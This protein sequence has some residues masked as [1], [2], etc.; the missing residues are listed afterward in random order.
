MIKRF[1]YAWIIFICTCIISLVGFGLV[2]NTVGLFY[3]PVCK[4]FNIGRGEVALM[5]TF[6]NIAAALTLAFAGKLMNKI[7]I[8]VLLTSTYL[9]IGLGL[10]GLSM[11]HSIVPF[12]VTWA[13]IGICEPFA[14]LLPIPVLLGNWFEK[15]LG[16]VMGISLGISA[17][18]GAVF[19]PIISSVITGSGWR[20][21]YIVSG[22]IVLIAILP[23]TLFLIK[24]KPENGV[25]PYGHSEN[26][27]STAVNNDS[28]ITLKQALKTPMFYLITLAMISLN[29]VAGF[30]QHI[31]GHIVNVGLPLTVGA[32]VISGVMLGAAA[33]KISIGWM[34]DKLNKSLVILIYGIFGIIGWGGLVV[35]KNASALVACGFI[36]GIGQGILLVSLPYFIR[37][38]FGSKDYSNIY[39]VISMFG[40]FASAAAVSIDGKIFD[41]T[42]SYAVPLWT[43]VALYVVSIMAIIISIN[44]TRRIIKNINR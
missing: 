34:L 42:K 32:S 13:L 22:A 5:T 25:Q 28:G 38:M 36:L 10:M 20:T 35:M 24:F 8:K 21:G 17:I 6:Q 9:V 40:A 18:G 4:A 41:M 30:V 16:T 23:L 29:Y 33:G 19:N 43:N 2:I 37:K 31:S 27:A 11:A 44:I 39:S 15:N 26:A 1:H 12:Y 7:N 14:I 3:G